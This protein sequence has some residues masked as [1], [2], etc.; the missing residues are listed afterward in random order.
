MPALATAL[1]AHFSHPALGSRATEDALEPPS[2]VWTADMDDMLRI[3]I[4][5]REFD[6]ATA[7]A[8]LQRYILQVRTSSGMLPEDVTELLYTPAACRA[9]WAQLDL[10]LCQLVER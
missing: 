1:A 9:R 5:Q 7:S 8:A 6:F 2:L 10:E 4:R 3:N